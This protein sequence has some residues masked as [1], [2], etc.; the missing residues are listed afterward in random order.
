MR[1]EQ[2]PGGTIGAAKVPPDCGAQK[3]G[4]LREPVIQRRS[5]SAL[6][7]RSWARRDSTGVHTGIGPYHNVLVGGDPASGKAGVDWNLK[8]KD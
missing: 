5:Q 2:E 8:L 4:T 7:A 6:G 3:V 1:I